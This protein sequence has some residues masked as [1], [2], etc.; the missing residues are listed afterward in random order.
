MTFFLL[1]TFGT[2]VEVEYEGNPEIFIMFNSQRVNWG[3][4]GPSW[5]LGLHLRFKPVSPTSGSRAGQQ[6]V[7]VGVCI[8]RELFRFVLII[9]YLQGSGGER[10]TNPI[11]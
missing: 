1:I 8:L 2:R 7:L 5:E 11:V 6:A 10:E 3:P 9:Q 4:R